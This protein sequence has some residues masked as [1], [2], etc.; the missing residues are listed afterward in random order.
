MQQQQQHHEACQQYELLA[1]LLADLVACVQLMQSMNPPL[2]G[3]PDSLS[4]T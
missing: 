2:Q 3:V 1:R 4:L